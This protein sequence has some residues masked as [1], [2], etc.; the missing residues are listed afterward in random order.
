[1]NERQSVSVIEAVGSQN[2]TRSQVLSNSASHFHKSRARGSV[3]LLVLLAA[4]VFGPDPNLHAQTGQWLLVQSN[5][6]PEWANFFR[7][8]ALTAP[9][10]WTACRRRMSHTPRTIG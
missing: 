3:S 6:V 1:M 7:S 8:S 4:L 10:A 2:S 9:P 5:A